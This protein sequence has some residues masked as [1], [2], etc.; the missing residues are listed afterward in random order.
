MRDHKDTKGRVW[1]QMADSNPTQ[2]TIASPRID[3]S[4]II[5]FY[6]LF[7]LPFTGNYYSAHLPFFTQGDSRQD[8]AIKYHRL[9]PASWVTLSAMER[10]HYILEYATRNIAD[11]CL[12]S[13]RQMTAYTSVWRVADACGIPHFFVAGTAMPFS[14]EGRRSTP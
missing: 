14:H 11:Q 3:G 7:Y 2:V 13:A 10:G 4:S 9:S 12:V 6:L 1:Y 5:D 8:E